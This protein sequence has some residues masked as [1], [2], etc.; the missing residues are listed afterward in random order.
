MYILFVSII[1]ISF[2]WAWYY[3]TN[4]IIY[5]SI[6]N[7]NNKVTK[8][9]L[10][11]IR[12]LLFFSLPLFLGYKFWQASLLPPLP[13]KPKLPP[14]ATIKNIQPTKLYPHGSIKIIEYSQGV[15]SIPER[16]LRTDRMRND[17]LFIDI[18]TAWPEFGDIA[19][20]ASQPRINRIRLLFEI[21]RYSGVP[22]RNLYFGLKKAQQKQLILDEVYDHSIKGLIGY[23]FIG[24]DYFS[25]YQILDN[26]IRSPQDTPIVISC[27]YDNATGH[28]LI[29]KQGRCRYNLILDS[30]LRVQ[31][32]FNKPLLKNAVVLHQNIMQLIHSIWKKK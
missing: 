19:Y 12:C 17:R 4:A 2:L 9:K 22:F 14:V 21:D 11:I 30:E 28:D 8:N 6:R 23:Q 7:K 3:I 1:L 27:T 18:E 26:N 20:Y 24:K 25:Y 31:I 16:A 29:T 32:R 15:F 10:F 13:I 5:L